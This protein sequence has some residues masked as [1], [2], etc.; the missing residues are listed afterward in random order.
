[1]PIAEVQMPNGKIAEFDVPDGTTP[2][3]VE[4]FVNNMQQP[5]IQKDSSINNELS[6][7][8]TALA[9][10]DASTNLF[11]WGDE[12]KARLAA[13]GAKAYETVSNEDLGM[14]Y[15]DY[16]TAG[17]KM[18][19]D[20]SSKF[21]K[22]NPFLSPTL[23][24]AG[25]LATGGLAFKGLSTVAKG[26]GA[27][28]PK[29]GEIGNKL[30]KVY[31]GALD[32]APRATKAATLGGTGYVSGSVY[33]G[34]ES[35]GTKEERIN[36]AADTGLVSGLFG[37]GFGV[38]APYIQ[39][40]ATRAYKAFRKTP[41]T[42][43]AISISSFD[44]VLPD[45]RRGYVLPLTKGEATQDLAT[46]ALEEEARRTA[47]GKF[48][49][50]ASEV[51][52]QFD[53]KRLYELRKVINRIGSDDNPEQFLLKA[54][55]EV[56]GANKT[57]KQAVNDAYKQLKGKYLFV[58]K[59]PLKDTL[60]PQ[61][62]DM[63]KTE[64]YDIN[65]FSNAGKRVVD[66][67]IDNKSILNKDVKS[68][69]FNEMEFWRRRLNNAISDNTDSFGKVSSEGSAL[70]KIKSKYDDFIQKIPE[71]AL[72]SGDKELINKFARAR[73][74]RAR[75]GSLFEGNN[76]IKKIVNSREL[77]NEEL[78]N[79]AFGSGVKS[80]SIDA[81]TGRAV[82]NLINA[83]PQAKKHLV[84]QNLKKGLIARAVKRA[85]TEQLDGS[86]NFNKISPLKLNKELRLIIENKTLTKSL[87]NK[88]ELEYITKLQ[89]DLGKISSKQDGAVNYS[90]TAYK[91]KDFMDALPF[92]GFG[93]GQLPTS[94]IIE[95]SAKRA[96]V[97]ELSKSINMQVNNLVGKPSLYGAIAGGETASQLNK[98]N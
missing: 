47:G 71:D 32:A 54:V 48:G 30:E 24:I 17:E 76:L 20:R 60:I 91:I 82:Q 42:S 89:N 21:E 80:S 9:A 36:A 29:V 78:A 43:P 81:G 1:M 61:V 59:Q 41:A 12:A 58:N 51:I 66:G 68:I 50:K 92:G 52:R 63:L 31:K 86:Y 33:G 10:L 40:L 34:G 19:R 87:F 88:K 73:S 72:I 37:T 6:A 84:K 74:M 45:I 53:S 56:R 11:G 2:Q 69:N 77:T 98:P 26:L 95:P 79:L 46:Q 75:F 85:T 96:A 27:V 5:P 38:A 65:N 62:K 83:V 57:A 64:G 90:N 94:T 13:L 70:L 35:N 67:L 15:D 23:N 18:L 97:M 22:E 44:K 14:S 28:A 4:N 7:G 3:E 16:V 8:D 39:K 93:V 55:S 25:D 49:E